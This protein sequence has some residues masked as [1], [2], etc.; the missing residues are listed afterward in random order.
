VRAWG[1]GAAFN[2]GLLRTTDGGATWMAPLSGPT[3]GFVGSTWAALQAL[4]LDAGDVDGRWWALCNSGVW[5]SRDRGAHWNKTAAQP[6]DSGD[7]QARD[8]R[9]RVWRWGVDIALAAAR[10]LFPAAVGRVHGRWRWPR[11][12]RQARLGTR[13]RWPTACRAAR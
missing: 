9:G 1:A 3:G 10:A 6:F 8:P 12:R 7:M 11:I 4:T 5:V 2:G 13:G